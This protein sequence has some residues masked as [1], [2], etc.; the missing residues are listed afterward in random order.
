VLSCERRNET[1]ISKKS[2][3]RSRLLS[4]D[5]STTIYST[6]SWRPNP[7]NR[8]WSI[9]PFKFGKSLRGNSETSIRDSVVGRRTFRCLRRI[10]VCWILSTFPS[11][12]KNLS[13]KEAIGLRIGNV[14]DSSFILQV[15]FKWK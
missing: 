2:S 12:M 13:K 1:D 5:G 7:G 14:T 10:R 8:V 11:K 4:R 15:T 9:L 6:A 3:T